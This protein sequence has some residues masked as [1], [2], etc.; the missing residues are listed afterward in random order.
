MAEIKTKSGRVL[1]DAMIDELGEACERGEYPGTPGEFL[2][3]PVGRPPLCAGEE[4]VTIAFKVPRSRRDQLDERA[5]REHESRSGIMRKI[6]EDAL[7][8]P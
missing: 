3:A 5:Q 7:V 2:V 6:L 1:T 4:L 8:V